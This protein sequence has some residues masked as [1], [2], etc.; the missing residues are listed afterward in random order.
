[1]PGQQEARSEGRDLF[2]LL[3]NR[4]R[5]A[6]RPVLMLSRALSDTQRATSCKRAEPSVLCRCM[7]D[8][9]AGRAKQ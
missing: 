7:D 1:M 2:D 4:G 6:I 8:S 9:Q 3:H 5:R